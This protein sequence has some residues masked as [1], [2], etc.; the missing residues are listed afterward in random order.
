[1]TQIATSPGGAL[2]PATQSWLITARQGAPPRAFFQRVLYMRFAVGGA[3]QI[4][5]HAATTMLRGAFAP[6]AYNALDAAAPP[7]PEPVLSTAGGLIVTLDVPRQVTHVQ[8]AAHTVP[9]PGYGL[10][11]Y[12]LDGQVLSSKPTLTVTAS[13]EDDTATLNEAFVDSRFALRLKATSTDQQVNL[14]ANTLSALHVMSYPTGPRIGLAPPD[15]PL[16]AVFFWQAPGEFKGAMASAGTVDAGMVKAEALQHHLDRVR[17]EQFEQLLADPLAALPDHIDIALVIQSDAPCILTI[18]GFSIPYHLVRESFPERQMPKYVLRFT[19]NR[20]RTEPIPLVLPGNATVQSVILRISESLRKELPVVDMQAAALK[21]TLDQQQGAYLDIER[22]VAQQI[23]P[24]QARTVSGISLGLLAIVADTELLIELHE[25][26]QD[27]PSGKKL[28]LGTIRL[29]RAGR[30]A[31]VL[32]LFPQAVVLATQPYWLL[33]KATR[34]QA[35]WLLS[36][37]NRPARILD[38]AAH[39]GTWRVIH[40]FAGLEA[41]HQLFEMS[42]A[43]LPPEG[44]TPTALAMSV[45]GVTGTPSADDA[46]IFDL[47]AAVRTYLAS[48]PAGSGLI[49]IPLS[50]TAVVPGIITVYPPRVEYSHTQ[51]G[52]TGGFLG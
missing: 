45:S 13:A 38:D 37:G 48:Q 35:I 8:L 30:P 3:D 39:T 16:A 27:Q 33:I 29:D 9:G 41:L 12:R 28:V 25:D 51:Q 18:D 43:A 32:Q 19:D 44:Q 20:R 46:R 42:G 2:Q 24:S 36:Q 1:M 22:W 4:V 40:N 47:T 5:V 49:A 11:F 6:Y 21:T 52:P 17:A 15:N 31:W 14:T 23:V 10:E 7:R 50:C 26:W 34:G